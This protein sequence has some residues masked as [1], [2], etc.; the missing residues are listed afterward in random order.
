MSD[1]FALSP[2]PQAVDSARRERD[3]VL[4]RRA[5]LDPDDIGVDVRAEERR[6]QRVLELPCE[7]PVLARDHGRGRQARGDLLRH[8]RAGEHRDRTPAHARREALARRRVESLCEAE[9][10]SV[11]RQRLDDVAERRARDGRDDDVDIRRSVGERDRL[12]GAKVDVLK[13]ARV[14]AGLG[15]RLRLL[16]SAAREHDLVVAIEEEA[17]ERRPPRARHRRRES[18]SRGR[19]RFPATG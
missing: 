15:D 18:A 12:R 8:V 7:V 10:R 4:R 17:R 13:V 11:A 14:P 6:A 5:Q 19:Y 3:D 1:A 16:G 2:S 9:D